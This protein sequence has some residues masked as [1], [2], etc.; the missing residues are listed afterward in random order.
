[1]YETLG[2]RSCGT[3]PGFDRDALLRPDRDAVAKLEQELSATIAGP[4]LAIAKEDAA[5]ELSRKPDSCWADDDVRFAKRHVE[6]VHD[7]VVGGSSRLR[8]LA[9][10]L[11]Q[12]PVHQT[13]ANATEF[14]YRVRRLT[15]W[16]LPLCSWTTKG[17]NEQVFA[18]SREAV[19][20]F[21]ARLNGTAYALQFGVAK[22]DASYERSQV[23]AE[24]DDPGTDSVSKLSAETL[25]TT[26]K[27]IDQLAN[28]VLR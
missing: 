4:H 11:D 22:D 2:T 1:M 23:T 25:A 27:Q 12:L 19:Q 9:P 28:L 26:R 6:M 5:Y 24:C 8:Q 3:P 15:E 21:E 17:S 16:M 18:A 7:G 10:A 13:P 14:R 20:Q